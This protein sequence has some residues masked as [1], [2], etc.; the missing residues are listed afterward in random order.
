MSL[1][2]RIKH[3][4]D[5][6]NWRSDMPTR[7]R[8]TVGIAGERF[9]REIMENGRFMAT[10]CSDCEITYMPPR[11]YCEQCFAQLD[12]WVE[13]DLVG[14]VHTFTVLHQNL[15]EE[16]L[17]KPRIIAFVHLD[18]TDGGLVHNLD[19][20]EPEEVYLG[21]PVEAVFREKDERRGSITDI[22]YFR[23]VS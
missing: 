5:A 18:D 11:L 14:H 12:D 20:V 23:P 6:V 1:L 3:A 21:M 19:E 10:A 9:F 22:K 13:V 17:P 7:G 16:P 4:G 15:D 8:Y 2:H